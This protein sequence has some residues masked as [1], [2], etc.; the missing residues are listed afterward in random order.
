VKLLKGRRWLLDYD[1]RASVATRLMLGLFSVWEGAKLKEVVET[2]KPQLLPEFWPALLMLAG[3]MQK[4]EALEECAQSPSEVCVDAVAA[5]VGNHE[6][7][8]R[9]RSEIERE[10]PEAHHL[11]GKAEGRTLVEAPAPE[12]SWAQ[13]A[14]MS[15]TAK[16]GRADAV[17]LHGLWGSA[18]SKRRDAFYQNASLPQSIRRGV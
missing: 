17:R 11:L 1:L 10:V 9:L 12:Y 7:V 14:F 15:P 2:F 3:R 6:A 18:R 16:E 8:E 4:E 13:L 5:T